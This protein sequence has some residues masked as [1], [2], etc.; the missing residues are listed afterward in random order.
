[1]DVG[2]SSP[3]SPTFFFIFYLLTRFILHS[4]FPDFSALP[5]KYK[6]QLT[7]RIL[8][9]PFLLLSPPPPSRS[10]NSKKQ[11]PLPVNNA[12]YHFISLSWVSRIP[13]GC[14]ML[15][16][17]VS[18]LHDLNARPSEPQLSEAAGCGG[19]L[20]VLGHTWSTQTIRPPI[21]RATEPASNT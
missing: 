11:I 18:Q 1:M 20:P 17:L 3:S 13:A 5:S 16:T 15:D 14:T 4:L 12:K 2:G 10:P 21:G 7:Y 19:A 9:H 8:P 6:K